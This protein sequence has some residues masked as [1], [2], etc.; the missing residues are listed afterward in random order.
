MASAKIAWP[1][2]FGVDISSRE[3]LAGHVMTTGEIAAFVG[4]NTLEFLSV[5]SMTDAVGS[6]R[7]LCTGCFTGSYPT[8]VPLAVSSQRTSR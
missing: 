5:E 7:S 2:F 6:D 3:E 4:A 1:C 8:R